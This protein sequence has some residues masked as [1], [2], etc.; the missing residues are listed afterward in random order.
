MLQDY[1]NQL[2]LPDSRL[3]ADPGKGCFMADW[4]LCDGST[5]RIEVQPVYCA[6]CGKLY[7]HIP[8][9]NTCFVCYF[10]R[11]CYEKYGT[12]A[13]T[14]AVP[15]QQ[16]AEAVHYEMIQQY[17]KDLTALEIAALADQGKLSAALVN[18][19]KDSPYP[20]PQS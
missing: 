7:G 1:S 13:G 12:I 3:A 15:D 11:Q 18:L 14:Y 10:C 17:G 20:V 2:V 6:N 16:F 9:E 8:K 4:Q 5:V 19:E